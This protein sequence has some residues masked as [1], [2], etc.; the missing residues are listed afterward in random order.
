M[1]KL[2]AYRVLVTK[3][4]ACR[5]CCG[6]TNPAD[7]KCGAFDSEEIGPWSLWPG[8]LDADILV[9]GQD[10]GDEAFFMKN[11][12]R[13]PAIN[14]TNDNLRALL[15]EIGYLKIGHPFPTHAHNFAFSALSLRRRRR[16]PEPEPG[17]AGRRLAESQG[18]AGA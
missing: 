17:R 7:P 6:L 4:K 15:K 16:E 2:E 13:D 8:C 5:L 14:P 18:A 3:R 12:G 10:W 1:N 9:V 11:N